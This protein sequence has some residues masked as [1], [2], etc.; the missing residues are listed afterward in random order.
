MAAIRKK[1]DDSNLNT[2]NIALNMKN[3]GLQMAPEYF[4]E[5][6]GIPT[7]KI[8]VPP[9]APPL[10]PNKD[11]TKELAAK[12]TVKNKLKKLYRK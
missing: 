3:A 11:V 1:E 2:A 10:D 7:S 6:T 4:Q 8:I 9:P 12:E 5:R